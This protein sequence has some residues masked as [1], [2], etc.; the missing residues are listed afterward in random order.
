MHEHQRSDRDGYLNFLVQ[1]VGKIT[2]L[3]ASITVAQP[4]LSALDIAGAYI[5][6]R[7]P[8]VSPQTIPQSPNKQNG[9]ETR[10]KLSDLTV[11]GAC[12][13][14]VVGKV[15]YSNGIDAFCGFTSP[16]YL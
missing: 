16:N 4:R 3:D 8:H 7:S 10:A 2:R 13:F 9:T 5:C 11:Y 1:T 14:K 12:L 15:Y 6:T